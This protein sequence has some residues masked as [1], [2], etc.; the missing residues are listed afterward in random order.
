MPLPALVS[1]EKKFEKQI[2]LFELKKG[3]LEHTKCYGD[4][5][6]KTQSLEAALDFCKKQ[7][8][9]PILKGGKELEDSDRKAGIALQQRA[10]LRVHRSHECSSFPEY[11][12]REVDAPLSLRLQCGSSRP[13]ARSAGASDTCD[14]GFRK[15]AVILPCRR[16]I[17]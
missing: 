15:L 17:P 11:V 5:L 4:I 16:E 7:L 3:V 1:L 8:D 10:F 13:W 2:K 6:H 12:L 14:S 9:M